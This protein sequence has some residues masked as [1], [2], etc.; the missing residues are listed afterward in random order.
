MLLDENKNPV[1]LSE[2]FY[3][4]WD[5]EQTIAFTQ[6]NQ[7]PI[8]W[9]SVG[10]SGVDRKRWTPYIHNERSFHHFVLL[11]ADLLSLQVAGTPEKRRGYITVRLVPAPPLP[12]FAT[13]E[14]TKL[15]TRR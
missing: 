12:L 14:R 15:D 5:G 13:Q 6:N 7:R 3:I 2:G 11:I 10:G 1:D 9:P 8:Y 4:V